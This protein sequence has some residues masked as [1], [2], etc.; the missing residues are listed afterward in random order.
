[1]Q[2]LLLVG[3]VVVYLAVAR[4]V[5]LLVARREWLALALLLGVI[6]YLALLSAGPETNTRFRFP[7]APFLAILAGHGLSSSFAGPRTR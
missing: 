1:V 2:A 6:V 7:A 4:G 5:I 3:L